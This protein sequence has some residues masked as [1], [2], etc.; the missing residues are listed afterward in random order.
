M[1]DVAVAA[2]TD[3]PITPGALYS[4]HETIGWFP[5]RTE[6]DYV[7]VL[8]TGF[9]VGAWA[10]SSLVGFARAIS[11][12]RLH[13]YLD[14]VMVHPDWRRQTV[15]SRMVNALFESL[16]NIPIVTLFCSPDLV[17]LYERAGF[18]ATRQVILHRSRSLP[19]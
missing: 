9:A 14:D 7:H 6:A 16:N 4:L 11:D 5:E 19:E 2:L 13:A 8:A 10:D 15:A 12:G 18:S 1:T 3:R 17:P